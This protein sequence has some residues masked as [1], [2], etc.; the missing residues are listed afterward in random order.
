MNKRPDISSGFC[1]ESLMKLWIRISGSFILSAWVLTGCYVERLVS[2]GGEII[3]EGEKVT[4]YSGTDG[5]NFHIPPPGLR[6]EEVCI[7][8]D[9]L[10]ILLS[11]YQ[12]G[13]KERIH[14]EEKVPLSEIHSL[15]VSSAENVRMFGSIGSALGTG[16]YLSA[17]YTQMYHPFGFSIS[18]NELIYPARDLPEDYTGLFH[19]N[20]A[21]MVSL[22]C[23]IGGRPDPQKNIWL[24]LELGPSYVNHRK[25]VETPNPDYGEGW[26]FPDPNK[27]IRDNVISKSVGLSI[28]LRCDL[29]FS[30]AVGLEVGVFGNL[31]RYK[32]NCGFEL[33]FLVGKVR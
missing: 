28:R 29:T 5:R 8:H 9:S 22:M 27:Y 3:R 6:Y 18:L 11:S 12:P 13:Q 14:I 31:N 21:T 32:P 20:N 23:A 24:G 2:D 7:Y 10:N 17:G 30:R 26:F 33:L 15:T 25:E 16:V 1:L 4:S 19:N